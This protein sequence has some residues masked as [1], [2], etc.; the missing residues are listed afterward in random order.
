[1]KHCLVG[2]LFL[3]CA[4]A[5]PETYLSANASTPEATRGEARLLHYLPEDIPIE[6]YIPPPETANAETVACLVEDAFRAWREVVPDL[7]S[8]TFVE[9]PSER[10]LVVVWDALEAQPGGSFE[11]EW[12]IFQGQ[13]R[14]RTTKIILDPNR[15]EGD[16]YRF[17]LL[18]VGH[19]LGLLGRSPYRGDA[20][21]RTP[22]GVISE[23]D[24][25]TLRALYRLPSGTPLTQ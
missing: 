25:A 22:S 20:M 4:L 6:V 21:S 14:F 15:N 18:Q 11:Y 8:F 19:A 12:S 24:I 10:S 9:W 7:V 2:L 23:R 5:Q 13:Y 3:G 16:L 17:A 1:M